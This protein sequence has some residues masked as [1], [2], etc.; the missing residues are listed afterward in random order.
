MRLIASN[1]CKKP[2]LDKAQDIIGKAGNFYWLL[3]GATPPSG[4]N[5]LAY[6][7]VSTLNKWL[8]RY[9]A[10]S[11]NPEE[12]LYSAIEQMQK[13]FKTKWVSNDYTPSSTAIIVQIEENQLRYLVL[14]DSSLSISTNEQRLVIT[15][16]RLRFIA[17]EEREILQKIMAK[18]ASEDSDEYINAR[19][20]LIKVEM[21]Y[22]NKEGGYWIAELNPEAAK[23]SRKGT[24]KFK[25]NDKVIVLA[26]SDGLERLVSTFGIYNSLHDIADVLLSGKEDI[27]FKQLREIESNDK[28]KYKTSSKH[29]D[30]SYLLL[31]NIV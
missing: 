10:T 23:K 14:G 9:A 29:D 17:Q 2:S 3:D 8:K 21:Q 27:V 4:N 6:E 19:N 18:G 30:A 26:V 16:T 1:V 20:N 7:Y 12:L 24:I 13:G 25:S 15:D 31:A 11:R 5:E 28:F 22:R